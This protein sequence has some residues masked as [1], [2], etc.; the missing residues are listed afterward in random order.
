MEDMLSSVRSSGQHMLTA[1]KDSVTMTP[2]ETTQKRAL[3]MEREAKHVPSYR[4]EEWEKRSEVLFKDMDSTHHHLAFYTPFEYGNKAIPGNISTSPNIGAIRDFFWMQRLSRFWN[5]NNTLLIVLNMIM[6]IGIIVSI[7]LFHSPESI[8]YA[9]VSLC[10]FLMLWVVVSAMPLVPYSSYFSLNNTTMS[11]MVAPSF[12][13]VSIVAMTAIIIALIMIPVM[14]VLYSNEYSTFEEGRSSINSIGSALI[15]YDPFTLAFRTFGSLCVVIL[16]L[17]VCM[18]FLYW[19]SVISP[20]LK[21]PL[22]PDTVDSKLVMISLH[23]SLLG[24]ASNSSTMKR[25]SLFTQ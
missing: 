25:M 12:A 7:S 6:F 24:G 4:D 8:P 13:T 5:H 11:S 21:L 10:I 17:I 15:T 16:P 3:A 9:S 19:D 1:M 22:N 18:C 14:M 20:N 23:K 2:K